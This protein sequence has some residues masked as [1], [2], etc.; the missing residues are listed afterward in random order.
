MRLASW[1]FY[2]L[3]TRDFQTV[4]RPSASHQPRR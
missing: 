3:L 1:L 2:E 4:S